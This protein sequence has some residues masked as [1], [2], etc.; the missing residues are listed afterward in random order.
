MMSH[1][2]TA[3]LGLTA[4]AGAAAPALADP[5]D[6][7]YS[8]TANFLG[9]PYSTVTGSFTVDF[10]DSTSFYGA[11]TGLT[12]NNLSAPYSGTFNFAYSQGY[13]QIV[14]S[15]EATS[16]N[17]FFGV[18]AADD[19]SANHFTLFIYDALSNAPTSAIQY[20]VDGGDRDYTPYG[21]VS[22][23]F[24][25]NAAGAGSGAVPEPASWA[26]MLGGFG[27][28]GGAMRSRKRSVSF[29]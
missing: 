7:T 13:D 23:S 24:T 15:D 8:F 25:D 5:I 6:R 11:V 10:D 2:R 27:L 16:T 20:T 4:L 9:A 17:P 22:F 3:L 19:S 29:A 21:Q 14:I 26:L 1:I 28:V 18:G 12:L